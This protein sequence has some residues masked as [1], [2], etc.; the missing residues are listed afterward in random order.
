M[1]P[2]IQKRR[3]EARIKRNVVKKKSQL[4]K[5]GRGAE[6]KGLEGHRTYPKLLHFFFLEGGVGVCAMNREARKGKGVDEWREKETQ[7]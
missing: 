5:G 1:E 7:A 2:R 4:K 6:K 3:K